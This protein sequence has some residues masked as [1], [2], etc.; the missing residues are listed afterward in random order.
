MFRISLEIVQLSSKYFIELQS[1]SLLS[2]FECM[3]LSVLK[4]NTNN[5]PT[6]YAVS[7]CRTTKQ[8]DGFR[9]NI[10]CEETSGVGYINK[11]IPFIDSMSR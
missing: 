6:V 3:Q 9:T 4:H 5:M 10:L 11:S 2:S 1:R 8:L 7:L